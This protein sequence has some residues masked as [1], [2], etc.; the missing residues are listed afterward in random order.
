[1][2]A[3][4]LESCQATFAVRKVGWCSSRWI[5]A[6]LK[7]LTRIKLTVCLLVDICLVEEKQLLQVAFSHLTSTGLD[8]VQNL[9]D[10]RYSSQVD[11]GVL[12]RLFFFPYWGFLAIGGRRIWLLLRGHFGATRLTTVLRHL[13]L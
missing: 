9:C 6:H 1:M 5:W 13:V 4:S 3:H 2:L 12:Q 10:F 7:G 8:K 11:L